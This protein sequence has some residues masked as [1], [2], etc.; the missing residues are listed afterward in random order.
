MQ[1]DRQTDKQTN[2]F[3][4]YDPPYSRGNNK[5]VPL[6]LWTH[7]Q[8]NNFFVWL[9]S[10]RKRIIFLLPLVKFTS[11]N[12]FSKFCL[13]KQKVTVV[14]FLLLVNNVIRIHD[15][16][17]TFGNCQKNSYNCRSDKS[18]HF[19]GGNVNQISYGFLQF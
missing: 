14:S 10:T 11:K 17:Q 4:S 16:F 7:N 9:F 13:S 6:T 15:F 12:F 8:A 1:T 5:D 19:N 18:S 2:E 3:F